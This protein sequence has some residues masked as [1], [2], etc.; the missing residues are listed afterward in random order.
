MSL[1][2]HE[3]ESTIHKTRSCCRLNDKVLRSLLQGTQDG[4]GEALDDFTQWRDESYLGLNV[5]KIK[6]MIVD[7][8]RQ[9]RTHRAIQIHDKTVEIVIPHN[10][11][12]AI[13]QDILK[14]DLNIEAITKK[15]HQRLPLLRKLRSFILKLFYYSFTE[16]VWTFSFGIRWFYNLNAKQRK[17]LQRIV[18]VCSKIICDQ[19]RTL[20]FLCVHRILRSEICFKGP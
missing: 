2:K 17:S 20:S 9:W 8:R 12:G 15:E 5:N 16:S 3:L 4:H 7:F 13:F 1:E 11:L 18:K 6:E 10:Y 19:V 14:C